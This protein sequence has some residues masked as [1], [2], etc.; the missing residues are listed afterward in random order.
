MAHSLSDTSQDRR[1]YHPEGPPSCKRDAGRVHS[2]LATL[3]RQI[4]LFFCGKSKTPRQKWGKKK[5]QLLA[6][7]CVRSSKPE[8]I[9]PLSLRETF[10]AT[11]EFPLTDSYCSHFLNFYW[12]HYESTL[13]VTYTPYGHEVEHW[14]MS[15]SAVQGWQDWAAPWGKVSCEPNMLIRAGPVAITMI[16]H[17]PGMS[18]QGQSDKE[19]LRS[20]WELKSLWSKARCNTHLRQLRQDLTPR[21]HASMP[22]LGLQVMEGPEEDGWGND[23]LLVTAITR[24]SLGIML[25]LGWLSTSNP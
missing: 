13:G 18:R 19:G 22:L 5:C 11:L 17:S 23:T 21:D 24:G 14:S 7:V 16:S 2:R 3:T 9:P 20:N 25:P 15:D 4:Y 10:P 1:T 6:V 12:C 8:K